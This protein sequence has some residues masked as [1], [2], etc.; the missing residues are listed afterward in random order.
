MVNVQNLIV[1]EVDEL[2]ARS[3]KLSQ[4]A[5]TSHSTLK[6]ASVEE[7]TAIATRGGQLIRRLY[8][9]DSQY[10]ERWQKILSTRS[11]TKMHSGYYEHVSEMVG[12]LRAIQHDIKSGLIR[13]VRG[14]LQAEIF[15]DFLDM[16]EHLLQEGYKDA[17]AVLLGAVMEDSLRKI[18]TAHGVNTVGPNGRPLT[19]DPL[20]VALAK[21]GVYNALVQKQITSWANLRND[22]A[23]ASFAKY[24]HET[25]RQMLMF[26]QKFCADYL[27]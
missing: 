19:I 8:V 9:G 5:S 11:F 10:L 24:D 7:L 20:N 3:E 4:E 14:L 22:A 27:V 16:T 26:V 2:V 15:A 13:N 21:A 17:A 6:A 23:H 18:A 25:V 1:A 12:V